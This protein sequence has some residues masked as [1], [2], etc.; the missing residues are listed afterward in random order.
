MQEYGE[1]KRIVS[2]DDSSNITFQA[3][4]DLSAKK[5]AAQTLL[6]EAE[7]RYRAVHDAT[8]DALPEVELVFDVAVRGAMVSCGYRRVKE[9]VCRKG[10]LE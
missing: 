3:L 7:A 10:F 2:I 8:P 4:K 5:T 1:A 9:F 6:A